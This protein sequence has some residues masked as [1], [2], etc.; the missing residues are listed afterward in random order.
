M[1]KLLL[2]QIAQKSLN[3]WATLVR[4]FVAKNFLNLPDL[5]T[6]QMGG[7]ECV[8]TGLMDEFRDVF[9]RFRIS[10]EVFTAIVVFVSFLVA[11]SCITPV[12]I[13]GQSYKASTIVIYDNRVVLDLNL[14]HITTLD[15]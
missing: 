3:I 5:A 13:S 9:R 7:L 11:L 6:L 1:E 12:K 2:F 14:P 15:L 10:R 4:T 8:I